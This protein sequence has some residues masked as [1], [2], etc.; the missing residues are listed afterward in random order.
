MAEVEKK[1]Q[2]SKLLDYYGNM[3]TDKQR[4]FIDLYY[5]ED[6]SLAEIAEHENI[7]RQGVR[8]S[9]KHG[10]QIL[11]ELES[12]LRLAERSETYFELNQKVSEL[13]DEIHRQCGGSSSGAK[14]VEIRKIMQSYKDL[15]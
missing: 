3:L 2:I 11:L 10:E 13:A 9:I 15:F 6:L 5:N 8:D 1:L 4:D 7:T 12:K 14:A